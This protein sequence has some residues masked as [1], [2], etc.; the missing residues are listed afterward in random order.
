LDWLVGL[1][2]ADG[3][4][5]TF[6]RGWGKLPFDRSGTDLTA[7]ALRAIDV[8]AELYDQRVVQSLL[9]SGLTFLKRSQNRDGSWTPLWFGNQDHAT[10][11]NR[12][13]GTAKVLMAYRDLRRSEDPAAVAGR[14]WLA[15]AQNADG[16]WGTAG[17]T[18]RDARGGSGVEETALAL[19]AILSAN[20]LSPFQ[21]VL[22]Q[23]LNWL[24][25]AIE[26]DQ[27]RNASP[28]GLY[29]AKLWYHE[30]LYPLIFSVSCLRMAV[31]RLV[32]DPTPVEA[33]QN[34]TRR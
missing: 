1:Q 25:T 8:W 12:I 22:Q 23:G 17:G 11:E 19:E 6:C 27:H 2:N 14:A 34:A 31:Q 33:P 16:G 29:F 10:E 4:W 24:T 9:K 32:S 5:P 15:D 26:N 18:E 30:R 7:H 28:I 21:T 20:D 13:Y 3:G